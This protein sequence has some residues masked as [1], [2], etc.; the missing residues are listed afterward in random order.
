MFMYVNCV[1]MCV[2]T[3]THTQVNSEGR[4]SSVSPERLKVKVFSPS[5]SMLRAEQTE[6]DGGGTVKC[7]AGEC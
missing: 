2:Y 1:E 5:D 7:E 3:H 6:E 4:S